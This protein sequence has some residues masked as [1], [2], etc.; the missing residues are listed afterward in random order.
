M[1]REM[2]VQHPCGRLLCQAAAAQEFECGD[3][4]NLC[5][6]LAGSLLAEAEALLKEGREVLLDV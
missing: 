4:T 6:M 1:L 2:D 5:V 3:A